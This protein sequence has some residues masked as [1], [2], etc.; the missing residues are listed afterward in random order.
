MFHKYIYVIQFHTLILSL[1][2]I[3]PLILLFNK[4]VKVNDRLGIYCAII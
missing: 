1:S 3:I 2:Y 4:I